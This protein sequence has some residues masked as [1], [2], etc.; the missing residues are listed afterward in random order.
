MN[1]RFF[2]RLSVAFSGFGLATLLF[3]LVFACLYSANAQEQGATFYAG[4]KGS[5]T[6]RVVTSKIITEKAWVRKVVTVDQNGQIHNDD[7][8]I[9]Q[10]AE[11]SAINEVAENAA[12]IS[13]AATA[14]MNSSLEYLLTKTNN[15]ASAGLGIAIAFPPETDDQNLRG[16]VVLTEY[17]NGKDIQYVHYNTELSLAPN[18]TVCYE[19]YGQ[20]T[21][22]KAA[23]K[24]KWDAAGTNM[25]VN[26]RTWS[27]V[28]RCEIDRPAW[29][30][31][32]SCL[33]LPNE[34]WGGDGGMEW[35]DMVLTHGGIPYFTGYVTNDV[36]RLVAYFD[37]GFLK[38]IKP[39]E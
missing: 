5:G 36:D 17:E 19:T 9:A 21:M 16:F 31:G 11:T 13:D 35:G 3:L 1:N 10:T 33:D 24:P 25:V 30:L 38:E 27:G 39:I 7:G 18:R 6:N 4:D 28:H 14:S 12:Q 34:T 22:V 20:K 29:C 15:M 26:G 37:N 2:I 23:W 8:K 32:K